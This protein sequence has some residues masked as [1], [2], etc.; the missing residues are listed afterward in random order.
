MSRSGPP[1]EWWTAAELAASG[2]PD[3]PTTK[4][5]VNDMALRL[6]WANAPGKSRK[7]AARGGGLEYHWSVLPAR[8][9]VRLAITGAEEVV[10]PVRA[11]DEVWAEFEQLGEQ[12]AARARQRLEVVQVVEALVRSGSRR[13]A[14]VRDIAKRH[15]VSARSIWNWLDM[16]RGIPPEDW[17][18]YLAP[19]HR[20]GP[21]GGTVIVDPD[22]GD[23]LKS[24]Y[25]RLA[26]PSFTSCYERTRRWAAKEGV[27]VPALHT[28]RRWYQRTTSTAM[29]VLARKGVDALKRLYPAQIR[30]RSG[31]HALEAICGDYH[32]FDVFVRMQT[33]DG[34]QV[35]RPQMVAFQDLF[36]GKILAWR[37][38]HSANSQ[39]VQL[40][41]GDLI[42]H[43]GIPK[44]A[45]LD[46]GR[47]FAAKTITGGTPTRFR[48]K[49][50]EEDIPGLL[51]TLGC[52]VH[53][54]TPYSGQSKPIERAFRDLCDRVAKH[55]ACEGAYTGNSPDAK[56]E[57]YA[58]RAL[59][60]EEFRALVDAEIAAHNARPDRRTEVAFG[61]SF[62]D[63]FAESYARAPIRKATAEQRRLWLMGARGVSV[64]RTNGRISFMGNA[65]FDEWLH[66]HLGATVVARFDADALWDG[67]HIY[68]LSGAYLGFA[69]CQEKV[70]FFSAEGAKEI[71]RARTNFT[72]AMRAQLEAHR[73]LNAAEVAAGALGAMPPAPAPPPARVVEMPV[74]HKRAARVSRVSAEDERP[75]EEVV[76]SLTRHRTARGARVEDERDLFARAL[77]FEASL[78]RG[79]ALTADQARWLRGYQTHPDYRAQKLLAEQLGQGLRG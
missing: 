25:L 42:E 56:P 8:A 60:F 69:P 36:S 40:C 11:R 4:R 49:V 53:W 38:S 58:S 77:E 76:T 39:T 54:A 47:E 5:R 35:V 3:L 17:L 68:A 37:L 45:L 9:R 55:P 14:A 22:F 70:G 50:T 64:N 19:R 67:L 27:P 33:P 20:R 7:R 79:E 52:E 59:E 1:Q 30:D 28:A 74:L 15:D 32:R 75:V 48:F 71:K 31:L 72:K 23:R 2:L 12:A 78:A 43:W 73:R 57:N 51:T 63:V 66:E 62:D 46:N 18:A 24:D 6:G 65:Y 34:E 44:H 13:D 21:T 41:L 29:E 16:V 61:R 26:Q 10:K